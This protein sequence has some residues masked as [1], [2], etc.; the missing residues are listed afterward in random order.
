MTAGICTFGTDHFFLLAFFNREKISKVAPIIMK[1]FQKSA[2]RAFIDIRP[3][4]VIVVPKTKK[5]T[6]TPRT[7]AIF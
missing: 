4:F 2:P 1:N 6:T 3:I 5:S 7:N